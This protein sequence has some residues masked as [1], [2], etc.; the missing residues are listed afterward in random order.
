MKEC[1]PK[2]EYLH[3]LVERSKIT[4]QDQLINRNST[5]IRKFSL[6]YRLPKNS[7]PEYTLAKSTL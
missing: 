6:D 2:K 3:K 1:R 5:L 7:K 4:C